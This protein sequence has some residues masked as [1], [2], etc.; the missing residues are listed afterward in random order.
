MA[1]ARPSKV[2]ARS[3]HAPARTAG[4]S[5]RAAQPSARPRGGER[6]AQGRP[7]AP[8]SPLE[9]AAPRLAEIWLPRRATRGRWCSAVAWGSGVSGA[10]QRHAPRQPPP[11]SSRRRATKRA[12]GPSRRGPKRGQRGR[13]RRRRPRRFAR[14]A[15]LARHAGSRAGAGPGT[16]GRHGSGQ[17]ESPKSRAIGARVEAPCRL[18]ERVVNVRSPLAHGGGRS[19]TH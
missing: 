17:T 4:P 19:G 11:A 9:T 2:L 7:R 12:M 3:V 6:G 15:G 1:S 5:P 18:A 14:S 10:V 16:N 8:R 13:R